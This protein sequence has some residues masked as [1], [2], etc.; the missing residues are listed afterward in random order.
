MLPHAFA[1]NLC[2]DH[3]FRE[4]SAE[5]WLAVKQHL[6][7]QTSGSDEIRLPMHKQRHTMSGAH[8]RGRR[9]KPIELWK[10]RSQSG[11]AF[12]HDAHSP[13][14]ASVCPVA[15]ASLRHSCCLNT[16][17]RCCSTRLQP[18]FRYHQKK[19]VMRQQRNF[20]RFLSLLPGSL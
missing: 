4:A 8:R 18:V 15:S 9:S 10:G 20:L 13:P 5:S 7:N 2:A 3:H 14:V 16:E 1:C 17:G 6:I 12:C 19:L 11:A